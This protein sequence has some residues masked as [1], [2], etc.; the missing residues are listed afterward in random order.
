MD[1]DPARFGLFA[2]P[3]PLAATSDATVAEAQR[4]LNLVGFGPLVVDG[5]KG[6]LTTAAVKRFQ[7]AV[8]AQKGMSIN[9]SG[10]LDAVT[11]NNLQVA[12]SNATRGTTNIEPVPDVRLTTPPVPVST[13]PAF[14]LKRTL[15]IA[16]GIALAAGALWYLLKESRGEGGKRRRS[17]A[18]AGKCERT[19]AMTHF[20]AAKPLPPPEED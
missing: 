4:L 1:F 17:L 6:P 3:A 16:G 19:P 8:A 20:E 12:A 2:A 13:A 9:P 10:T 7:L 5:I 11:V 14:D 18:D 15:L